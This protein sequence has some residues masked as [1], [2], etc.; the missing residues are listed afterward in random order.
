MKPWMKSALRIL[1]VLAFLFGLFW[2]IGS[3]T[4]TS[5]PKPRLKES[6]DPRVHIFRPSGSIAKA[7]TLTTSWSGKPRK[8]SEVV[9]HNVGK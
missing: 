5:A 1:L 8:A 2:F 9:V 4:Y 3:I 7:R 6:T